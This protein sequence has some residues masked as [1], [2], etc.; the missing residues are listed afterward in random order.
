M[1]VLE[2]CI[3]HNKTNF[4]L[5]SCCF[6]IPSGLLPFWDLSVLYMILCSR[7]PSAS[8]TFVSL[9]L[10]FQSNLI[11]ESE[12]E[13]HTLHLLFPLNCMSPSRI[14]GKLHKQMNNKKKPTKKAQ[15]SIIYS[16]STLSDV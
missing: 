2:G 1:P 7:F 8:S 3:S 16:L 15:K 6:N 10:D 5:T 9:I 13:F 14:E 4:Q 11:T 12:D